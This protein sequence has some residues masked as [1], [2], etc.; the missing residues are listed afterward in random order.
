MKK[1]TLLFIVI[2]ILSSITVYSQWIKLDSLAL[3]VK[4]LNSN[5]NIIYAGTAQEG[6][7]MSNDNGYTWTSMNNSGLN[8]LRINK[9]EFKDTLIF[10]AT[11][12]GIYC[13]SDNGISWLDRSSGL[14]NTEVTDLIIYENWIFACTYGGGIYRSNDNGL[15]WF[16]INNGLNETYFD[17][18]HS[19]NEGIY[20]GS[21]YGGGG[22]YYTDN[23]GENWIEKNNGIPNNPWN[24]DKYADIR[25]FTQNGDTIYASVWGHGIVKS[26]NFGDSWEII[27]T[28]NYF[29]WDITNFENNLFAGHNGAGFSKSNDGGV[30]WE[31]INNGLENLDLYS[32]HIFN[33]QIYTGTWSG[34]IYSQPI[35]SIITAISKNDFLNNFRIFPNPNNG[36]FYIENKNVNSNNDFELSIL[37]ANLNVIYKEQQSKINGKY[38]VMNPKLK[39][40]M[41]F[42]K[43]RTINDVSLHKIVVIN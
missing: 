23:Y 1:R 29:I 39:S 30:S 12:D 22:I 31:F 34:A 15:S 42:L 32:L 10:V 11:W 26:E 41:Y 33:D 35:S 21:I 40:G 37:D 20:V 36:E 43:I 5:N 3:I 24:P 28:L 17:C 6:L 13:T 38:K 9:I 7:F 18:L 8:D 16:A 19:S 14:Q 27:N 4:T 25:D 2:S